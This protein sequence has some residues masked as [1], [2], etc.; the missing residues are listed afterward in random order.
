MIQKIGEIFN[1]HWSLK[2]LSSNMTNRQID[3]SYEI[4]INRFNFYGGKLIELR[5]RIFLMVGK[6]LNYKINE[7]KN[8]FES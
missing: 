5:W 4:L 6:N 1:K 2:K 8:G 7:L 3:T